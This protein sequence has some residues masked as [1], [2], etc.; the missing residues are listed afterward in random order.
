M[1]QESCT[2]EDGANRSVIRESEVRAH[3]TSSELHPYSGTK[4]E[5]VC[6][7]LRGVCDDESVCKRTK[8]RSECQE[9]MGK[10]VGSQ[11]SGIRHQ[12]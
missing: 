1:T 2:P 9:E 8:F 11:E 5:S 3:R 4:T 10:G 6:V 7:S 12:G